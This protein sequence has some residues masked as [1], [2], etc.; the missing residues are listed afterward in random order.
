M[1]RQGLGKDDIEALEKGK[2]HFFPGALAKG[3]SAPR[4]F[5]IRVTK[6]G[7]RSF[8]LRYSIAGRDRLLVIGQYPTWQAA[9]AIEEANK[10]RRAIDSGQDPGVVRQQEQAPKDTVES[11]CEEYFRREGPKLRTAEDRHRAL[12]RLVYPV[13]GARDIL[14]VKRSEL[15]S[16]FD[17]IEDANGP[18]MSDRTLAYVSKVFNWFAKRSDEF[19]TPI[20]RGMARTSQRDRARDRTLSDDELRAVWKAAEA[21][22]SPFGALVRFILLTACRRGEASEL[23]WSEIEGSNWT[24]PAARNKVKVDLVRPL[25]KQALA[26]LPEKWTQWVFSSDGVRPIAG[27]TKFREALQKASGTADWTLHDL[28]R[29]ARSLMSRPETGILPDDAER[30]LGHVIGGVR[31]TYDRWAYLPQ[32]QKAYEAL[33]LLIGRIVNPADNVVPLVRPA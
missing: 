19:R 25:T 9:A 23:V 12:K 10:L 30:C 28:R 24:L 21:S 20:V 4:G 15:V 7:T 29:T 6:N 2:V 14:T 26:L 17:D 32:K 31:G 16:L 18:V 13:L 1:D 8:I 5:G 22:A 33:A 11:V 3:K 27:F